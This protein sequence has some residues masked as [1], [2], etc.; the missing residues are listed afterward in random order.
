MQP[1]KRKKTCKKKPAAAK[2]NDEE[3]AA[4]NCNEEHE[5]AASE[6][7][8]APTDMDADTEEEADSKHVGLELSWE[9]PAGWPAEA[10]VCPPGQKS[11]T[12]R[13]PQGGKI[14]VI[15]YQKAFFVYG[16]PK[17]QRHVS[18]CQY[19]CYADAWNKAKSLALF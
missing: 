15:T 11:W 6:Q 19:D 13:G 8:M 1:Q 9:P 14:G 4:A 3:A 16:A 10:G 18:W 12:A 2:C 5:E 7:T 17:G